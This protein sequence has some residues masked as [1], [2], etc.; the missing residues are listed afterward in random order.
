MSS[1]SRRNIAMVRRALILTVLITMSG[2]ARLALMQSDD[3]LADFEQARAEQDYDRALYIAEHLD[4]HH[5]DYDQVQALLTPLRAEIENFE[6][7]TIKQANSLANQ[8]KWKQVW[9]LLADAMDQW[10]PSPAL[11]QARERLR[12]R[13]EYQRRKTTGDLLLAETR[14]RLSSSER[15]GRLTNYTDAASENRY[16]RWRERNRELAEALV[17]HGRWFSER[18]DWQRAHDYLGS[19]QALH[20]DTVPETLLARVQDKHQARSRR[21]EAQRERRQRQQARQRRE[22][23]R[24]LLRQYRNTGELDDL[25]QLRELIREDSGDYLPE[26]LTARVEMLSRERFRSAMNEG[27]ARY[28]RGDYREARAIWQKIQPL[29]PP[30]SEV[31]EK[32]ERVERVLEK[33]QNLEGQ[34]D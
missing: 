15:A 4:A 2:C 7:D 11:R 19:A 3:P 22:Q 27:D 5:P 25:L 24:S 14:W 6:Q 23:A 29:A 16:E 1:T 12:E 18:E 32:L 31:S 13:E 20:A 21:S 17:E 26:E 8:G 9:R 10:R 30:D 28:A 33:L 34:K